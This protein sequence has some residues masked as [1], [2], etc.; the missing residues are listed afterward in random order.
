MESADWIKSPSVLTVGRFDYSEKGSAMDAFFRIRPGAVE[1]KRLL[2]RD[3][4]GIGS[5]PEG[6]GEK[7][8]KLRLGVLTKGPQVETDPEWLVFVKLFSAAQLEPLTISGKPTGQRQRVCGNRFGSRFSN[9]EKIEL[10]CS[11]VALDEMRLAESITASRGS[12]RQ[13][14]FPSGLEASLQEQCH[15]RHPSS[16]CQ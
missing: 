16:G 8:I 14:C 7:S 15:S 2:R 1:R 6:G 13:C 3:F 10:S 11:R 4:F 5:L 9:T 12:L